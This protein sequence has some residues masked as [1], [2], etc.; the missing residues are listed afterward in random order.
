[1]ALQRR[2]ERPISNAIASPFST[3][4]DATRLLVLSRYA[5]H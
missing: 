1:M 3:R 2:L 4:G 5:Q